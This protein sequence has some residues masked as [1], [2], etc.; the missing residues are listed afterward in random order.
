MDELDRQII[1]QLQLDCKQTYADIGDKVGVSAAT[2]HARA[3]NLEKKGMILSYGARVDAA[4]MGL[5]VLAFISVQLENSYSCIDIADDLQHLSEIEDC[6]SVAGDVDVLLKARAE[7]PAALEQLLYEIKKIKGVARTRTS[8][9]LTTRFE[10]RPSHP[11]GE[12]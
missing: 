7:T 8:V 1:L 9:V 5:P 2:V 4:Q 3:K 6:F 12:N 11:V 10:G